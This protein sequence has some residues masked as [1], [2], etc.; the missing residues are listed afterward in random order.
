MKLNIRDARALERIANSETIKRTLFGKPF[1]S[2]LTQMIELGALSERK[3]SK[4]SFEIS[5]GDREAFDGYLKNYLFV[6]NIQNYI[7][8]QESVNPSRSQLAKLNVSTKL[9]SVNPKSGLHLDSPD[10]ITIMINEQE[11]KLGFP[12]GCALFI[13]RDNR[14]TLE[15][16]ILIVGV[17]NFEN[18]SGILES[19]ELLPKRR[20]L[21]VERNRALQNLLNRVDNEYL[22]FGDI[23]LAGISIFQSE[24]LPI[25]GERGS[26]FIP[27]DIENLLH[28]RGRV[29][30]Y[31]RH[32][33]RYRDLEGAT[34]KLQSLIDMIRVTKSSIEQEFF[35]K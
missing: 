23:D 11:V 15:E 1:F 18:L 16:D 32:K 28:R 2:K 10:N 9:K 17:E 34:P 8:A 25:V 33:S 24:Y 29:A 12:S 20:L 13:H 7:S 6:E 30:L 26:F 14:I 35:N 5:M 3:V 22:H 27:K 19:R 4:N 31:E 21:L